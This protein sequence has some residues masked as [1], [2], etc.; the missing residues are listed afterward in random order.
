MKAHMTN[1]S[2][3]IKMTLQAFIQLNL[4]KGEGMG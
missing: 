1:L 2:M 3:E 4:L